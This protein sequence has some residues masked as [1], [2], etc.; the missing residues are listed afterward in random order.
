[1]QLRV[2]SEEYLPLEFFSEK[3]M[4]ILYFFFDKSAPIIPPFTQKKFKQVFFLW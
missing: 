3:N 4:L 2:L 1:M